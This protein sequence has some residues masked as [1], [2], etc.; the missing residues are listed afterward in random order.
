MSGR[1][2]CIAVVLTVLAA[3]G[4]RGAEP[5]AVRAAIR[6]PSMQLRAGVGFSPHSGLVELDETGPSSA[7]IAK[8]RRAMKG[9]AS[10]APRYR[11]LG[12]VYAGS[13]QKAE[14][15]Q[16]YAKAL[17]L[18]EAGLRQN[19]ADGALSAAKGEV[20]AGKGDLAGAEQFLKA[21]ARRLP[22]AWQV[23]T[24]L[25]RVL[26]QQSWWTFWPEKDHRSRDL[27]GLLSQQ[28]PDFPVIGAVRL[29]AQFPSADQLRTAEG[30]LKESGLAFDAAVKAAPDSPE[31]YAE[32]LAHRFS[33]VPQAFVIGELQ[34]LGAKATLLAIEE[35]LDSTQVAS[36]AAMID[37]DTIADARKVAELRRNDPRAWGLAVEMG[38]NV[39]AYLEIIGKDAAPAVKQTLKEPYKALVGLAQQARMELE[40]MGKSSSPQEAAG[41]FE[42]LGLIR[43]QDGE[44][45]AA[46][47]SLRKA[48]QLDPNVGQAWELLA[49]ILLNRQQYAE[50]AKLYEGLLTHRDS[51]RAH[52][53][54]A[55]IYERLDQPDKVEAHLKA[56]LALDDADVG[57]RL[58]NAALVL[59]NR[60]LEGVA[61]AE[62]HLSMAEKTL[63]TRPS[64]IEALNVKYVRAAV[65]ALQ[66]QAEAARRLLAEVLKED[67]RHSGALALSAALK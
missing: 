66:G 18:Y 56:A 4:V 3:T 35:A 44:I 42:A 47:G 53:V 55:K 50:L 9:D 14:A 17:E 26:R 8:L 51:T 60:G 23:Q 64:R 5:S 63:E 54:L 27:L 59:H 16:A 7:A 39:S 28:G 31:P 19:P 29:K 67:E 62:Q 46:E 43:Y 32:R 6:L 40:R 22:T 34:K 30:L 10:D 13:G 11:T 12:A 37:P 36:Q 49:G 38:R 45:E 41:A 1:R 2:G 20:L 25:G 58:Y 52:L 61:M 57:T 33:A 24:T 21:E 48:V 65:L 15:Q